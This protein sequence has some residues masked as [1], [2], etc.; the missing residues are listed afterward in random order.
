MKRICIITLLLS[1]CSLLLKAQDSYF[2]KYA[3]L[4]GVTSVYISKAM[5]SLMPD[6]EAEGINI[7]KV[8][9]KLD[10][11][12]ILTSEKPAIIEK[13]KKETERFN[14]KNGYEELMRINDGGEKTTIY[15]KEKKNG[16]KELV[17]LNSEENEFSII[18]ITGNLSLKEIQGIIDE[19]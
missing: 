16:Q 7:G 1:A 15:L 6:M 10:N 14:T 17:L 8:A 19:K 18:V 2:D 12:Q 4:D 3:G 11:L 9:E 5:L 13:L